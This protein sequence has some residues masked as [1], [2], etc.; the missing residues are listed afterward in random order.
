MRASFKSIR[1]GI[2]VGIGGG[3]TGAE[4]IRLGDVVVSQPQATH[5]GV[6]QY[7]SGKE[8]PSGFQ[9]TGSLD[10]PPRILL[11]AVTKVRANELRGRSTLSRHLSSLDCNTRFS[12]EKAGPEIL[13]HADY[14]HIRGH[15]CDS[16]DPSRRSNREPRG[17]KEDVAVHYGTI[18][19]GNKVMRRS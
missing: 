4:D 18:A 11:S 17:R 8:T 12:R 2:M 3:V 16:C 19:S 13:F 7:D 9:R 14:D 6:V 1:F 10:S 15:T 5:G